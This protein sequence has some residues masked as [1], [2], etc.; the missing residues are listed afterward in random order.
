MRNTIIL[1]LNAHSSINI[2]LDQIVNKTVVNS[3]RMVKLSY[4]TKLAKQ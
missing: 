3:K 2:T 1:K 4:I